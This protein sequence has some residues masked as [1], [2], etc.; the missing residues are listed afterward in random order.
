MAQV[1]LVHGGWH[2]AWCWD[3]VIGELRTRD[4]TVAAPELPL[5]S[6]ADDIRVVRA[7]LETAGD[8]IVVCGHSYG[9][10]VISAAAADV[11]TVRRLVYLCAFMVDA[12]EDPVALL[13]GDGTS[14]LLAAM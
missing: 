6:F 2:G 14:R 8:D 11:P 7:A 10:C 4:V 5:T 1:V 3:A 13:F 12:G 9:G